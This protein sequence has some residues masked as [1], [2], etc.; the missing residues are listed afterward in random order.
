[1]LGTDRAISTRGDHHRLELGRVPGNPPLEQNALTGFDTPGSGQ[2][3]RA[4]FLLQSQEVDRAVWRCERSSMRSCIS[5][6]VGVNG[7]CCL[8]STRRGKVCTATSSSGAMMEGGNDSTTR[9]VLR[10][11]SVRVATSI[12]QLEHWTVRVS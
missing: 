11:E 10:Y 8:G 12:Q 5:S 7:A 3:L 6:S 9:C 2:I 4:C 1:M